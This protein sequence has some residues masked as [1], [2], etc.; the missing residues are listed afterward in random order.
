MS[1]LNS[2]KKCSTCKSIKPL[3]GFYNRSSTKDGVDYSCRLCSNKR[4]SEYQKTDKSKRYQADYAKSDVGRR[5]TVIRGAKY[6]S[7][8]PIKRKA[9]SAISN[10]I[11]AGKLISP[12]RCEH[13]SKAGQVHA[14]HDDYAHP[15]WVRW[16]CPRCHKAW[17]KVNGVGFNG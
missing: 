3:S 16:L 17:H 8:N 13:C 4:V 1:K 10:A 6:K 12:N 5:S 14:H 9:Q 7:N 2:T 15:L 11:A